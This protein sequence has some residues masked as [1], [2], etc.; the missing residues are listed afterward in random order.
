MGIEGMPSL[1]DESKIEE[2]KRKETLETY[3]ETEE[4]FEQMDKNAKEKRI[5]QEEAFEEFKTI[6]AE[7]AEKLGNDFEGLD[8]EDAERVSKI[9]S[10]CDHSQVFVTPLCLKMQNIL[11]KALPGSPTNLKDNINVHSMPT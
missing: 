10:R 11:E 8:V 2:G 9:V 4:L 7:L 5:R 6:E 3:A 1:E